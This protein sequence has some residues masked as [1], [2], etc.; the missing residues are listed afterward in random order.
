MKSK[1][2]FRSLAFASTVLIA[3]FA[4]AQSTLTWDANGGSADQTDGGGVW[5]TAGQWWNGTTNV[6]WASGD[7]AIFGNG[8]T[9]GAVTLASPTTIGSLTFNSF[10]GTYTLGTAAQ[11]IT[12]NSGITMNS[13]AGAAT[14]ISPITLG[15][16]Q[17]WLNNSSSLL[18]VG[19]G[20]ITNGGFLL[21]V[22]GSGNTSISSVIGGTG[23]LTKQDGGILTLSGANTFSGQLTVANGTLSIASIN[24]ASANGTLGNS[25]SAVILGSSGNTGTLQFTGAGLGES[26]KGFTVATGGTGSF[27]VSLA[28]GSL[29]LSTAVG[30]SGNLLKVGAGALTLRGNNNYSGTTTINGGSLT[31]GYGGTSGALNT[32]SAISVGEGAIFAVNRSDTV[33]QGSQ[34]STAAISGAGGFAQIGTG[35]TV[36]NAANTYT[37]GTTISRGTLSISAANH[38]GGASGDLNFN[39]GRLQIT[40]TALNSFTSLGRTIV[41]NEKPVGLDINAAS[42]TFTFDQ[43]LPSGGISLTGAGTVAF[44]NSVSA[45]TLNVP[46]GTV[47]YSGAGIGNGSDARSLT[48]IGA[49]TQAL[50]SN[51]TFTGTTTINAGELNLSGTA[52]RLSGTTALNLNGGTLNFTNTAA[53][54]DRLN[55]TATITSN[56][57]IIRTTN[58]TGANIYSETFG[59]VTLQSGQ[60]TFLHGNDYTASAGSQTLSFNSLIRTGASNTSTVVFTAFTN[61]PS[62]TKNIMINSAIA[63]A[64][65]TGQIIAPWFFTGAGALTV[66]NDYGVYDSSGRVTPANIAGSAQTTW[67]TAANAYTMSAN[68]TLSETRTITALRSATGSGG[69]LTLASGANLETYGLLTGSQTLAV[70]A[71]T[72]GVMT[73]PTGGGNLFITTGGNN[74]TVAA[75]INDNSGALTLVKSGANNLTLSS[76]T[77]NFTGGTVIN[78]GT[79]T[80][81]AA[82]NLGA[83]G[84]RNVTF[85]GTGTLVT[86]TNSLDTLNVNSAA[87]ATLSSNTTFTT[88]NGTGTISSVGN[89]LSLGNAGGFTGNVFKRDNGT[90]QFASLG[91]GGA[92]Q[93]GGGTGDGGQTVTATLTGG[94]SATTWNTRIVEFIPR[95]LNWSPR[96]MVLNNNNTSAAHTLTISTNLLN[97]SDR[98]HNF[99]LGGSNIGNNTFAGVIGNSTYGY[100]YDGVFSGANNNASTGLL[101]LQKNDAGTWVLGDANTYTG[102]TTINAGTL[103]VSSL[104]NGGSAS[105]LGASS[106]AAGSLILN[107]GMLRYTGAAASTDRGFTLSA[108]SSIDASG[109]GAINF[110]NTA[111]PAYGAAN[112]ARGLTLTG[113]NTGNNTLAATL[114]NN[115]TGVNTLTK[116]GIGTWV[117]SG[118]NSFTGTT[119]L[120]GGGTLVLDFSSQNSSKLSDTSALTIGAGAGNIILRGGT[121]VEAVGGITSGSSNSNVGGHTSITRDGGSAKIALGVI[122]RQQNTFNTISIGG[123]DIATTTSTNVNGILSG[124]ITVGSNWAKNDGS[125][126]II[127]LTAGDYTTLPTGGALTGTTNYQLTG[128]L[129]RSAAT[130]LNSLRIVGDDEDQTL[131]MGSFNLNPSM[132]ANAA[133]AIKDA[134]KYVGDSATGGILYAGG[135]NNNYTIT[136]TGILSAQNSGQELIINTFQGTL[137]VDMVLATGS[138]GLVKTGAGTLVLSKAGTYTG[139]THINQGTMR[140]TNASGAGTTGGITVHNGGALELAN[141]ISVAAK[142]TNIRGTG[143]S[144][145]GALRNL[146]GDNS[147]AGA[148]TIGAGGARI[149]SESGTMTLTGGV[150]TSVLNDVTFGGAGD[151]IASTTAI[152]GA[153]GLA[154]DGAGR[155]TLSTTNTYTGSTII[156]GGVLE[157]AGTGSINS[158]SGITVGSAGRLVY[159]SSTA[160]SAPLTISAGGT[161]S[162]SGSIGVDLGLSSINSV[163]SPGN[164]PGIQPYGVSQ[165]WSAFTYEWELNEWTTAAAGTNFDQI[166]ITGNLSLTGSSTGSYVLNVLSL[167]A[168]NE[169]GNVPN[170]AESSRSWEILTT[171]GTIIGFDASYWEINTDGFLSTPAWQ[172][173]W[174]LALNG[175]DN[176]LVLSFTAIPEPSVTLL[177]GLGALAL[178]R[179]RRRVS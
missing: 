14:I 108:S 159:N 56:G 170:F 140:L 30:G 91:D 146:S 59:G 119:T 35:T 55:D 1:F 177:G 171:T 60:T 153:G 87:T 77:S 46:S 3:T 136:G 165:T 174:S 131:N 76:T 49:G 86:G 78:A 9:G 106:N 156:S 18:N 72:G 22:G 157:L 169:A 112:T 57:G 168:L 33:T 39:G 113:T 43:A 176:A 126:N 89:T 116:S 70:N 81:T 142:A 102:S 128:S 117:L 121:H 53:G 149:N 175:S 74:I 122:T 24:N 41:F 148:I 105:S 34:F 101:S 69:T 111:T 141:D 12:L 151:T 8:G 154:K 95:P 58:N 104:A 83:V 65:P 161:L 4:H 166:A 124:G 67:T 44:Q 31:I 21:T 17:S 75:P 100:K 139:T 42:N 20:A 51:N 2:A 107:G 97:N 15:A 63:S 36:L 94:T 98:D 135:G 16:A 145:A 5:L 133:A 54:V 173:D 85:A 52:G 45:L 178:L 92:L 129:T 160:L 84:S 163:L 147:Y 150:V 143:I 32:G 93:F 90:V 144:N 62:A 152:S 115:G 68:Q 23:G 13:G 130:T 40:G 61:G 27:D 127:A 79:V 7:N 137:N 26:S 73:T 47:T 172:G 110:T 11:T 64:T 125:G 167:T 25:A 132:L 71:G 158:S 29:N 6:S 103:Q 96:D 19:T 99:R 120:T 179:R 37:G 28:S 162:G 114:A 48:K 50:Q 80:I 123:D 155:L 164:S 82:T 88:T 38:L 109:T 66:M 10:T 138:N 134:N 118:N